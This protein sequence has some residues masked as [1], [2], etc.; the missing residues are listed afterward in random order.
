MGRVSDSIQGGQ[1]EVQE[2]SGLVAFSIVWFVYLLAIEVFTLDKAVY[3][4]A[5]L[6]ISYS[7]SVVKLRNSLY[8]STGNAPYNQPT[9]QFTPHSKSQGHVHLT[10]H[11]NCQPL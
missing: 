11:F 8:R 9:S 5:L 7:S 1:I 3:V 10:C 6:A 4:Q 2:V